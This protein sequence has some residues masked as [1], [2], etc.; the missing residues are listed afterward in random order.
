[1]ANATL[2]RPSQQA[3]IPFWRDIRIIAILL[4]VLFVIVVVSV[5]GFLYN[6]MVEGLT[7]S[8]LLP[9]LR[10]LDQPAGIVISEGIEYSPS[11]S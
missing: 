10:Y 5:L 4:Q 2:P 1:M 7:R 11:D 6:N 8:N 3:T 9:N